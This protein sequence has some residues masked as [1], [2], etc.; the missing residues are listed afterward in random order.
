MSLTRCVIQLR[1]H[2]AYI[3]TLP[4]GDTHELSI[5]RGRL[6]SQSLSNITRAFQPSI[7]Q[8]ALKK[9]MTEEKPFLYMI[10][11]TFDPKRGPPNLPKAIK[12]VETR[13]NTA[14]VSR[15]EPIFYAYA[16]EP[17]KDGRPHIHAILQTKKSVPPGS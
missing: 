1:N 11:F 12:L 14:T 10:T 13:I 4:Q 15:C 7:F 3:R 8:K 16:I 2:F 6:I 9:V 17:H 5:R